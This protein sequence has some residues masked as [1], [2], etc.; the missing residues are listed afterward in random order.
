MRCWSFLELPAGR[1]S[2]VLTSRRGRQPPL[3]GPDL[4]TLCALGDAT[5]SDF[6][7]ELF[8]MS[9]IATGAMK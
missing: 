2:T 3:Y 9:Q 6:A 4:A 5:G 7:A 8:G 1:R